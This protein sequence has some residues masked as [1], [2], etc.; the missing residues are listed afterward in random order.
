MKNFVP[1]L[2]LTRTPS[3]QAEVAD[4]FKKESKLFQLID[5]VG[6]DF[7]SRRRT[8]CSF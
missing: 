8:A 1:F 2:P 7:F 3:E 6:K 4:D 5:Q